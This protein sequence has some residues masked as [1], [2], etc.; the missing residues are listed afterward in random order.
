MII[1]STNIGSGIKREWDFPNKEAS[2][3][4][5]GERWDRIEREVVRGGIPVLAIPKTGTYKNPEYHH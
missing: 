1:T 3:V 2:V 5:W 4:T